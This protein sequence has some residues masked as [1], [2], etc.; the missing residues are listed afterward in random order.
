MFHLCLLFSWESPAPE[1]HLAGGLAD[2]QNLVVVIFTF[3]H[4]CFFV[5]V[6]MWRLF[7]WSLFV[8]PLILK[9]WLL[10]FFLFYVVGFCFVFMFVVSLADPS[11]LT[12]LYF[13]FTFYSNFCLFVPLLIL[14]IYLL[15]LS[16]FLLFCFPLFC[17]YVVFGPAQYFFAVDYHMIVVHCFYIA[18]YE[19][20]YY[21]IFFRYCSFFF[22]SYFATLLLVAC[23]STLFLLFCFYVCFWRRSI[24]VFRWH[25][26]W[27]LC[28]VSVSFDICWH[29]ISFLFIVLFFLFL[30]ATLLLVAKK[31]HEV[32]QNAAGTAN[33]SL[34]ILK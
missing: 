1:S 30:F 5:V 34:K 17:F 20:T 12:L 13:C 3:L 14:E 22:L 31:L 4:F 32:I 8:A 7:L 26:I 29:I 9:I 25:I 21:F 27:S 18:L 15:K 11:K 10:T 24:S 23:F 19:L 16:V 33:N 2:P 6:K 28:I